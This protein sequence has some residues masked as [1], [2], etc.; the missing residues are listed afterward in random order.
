MHLFK[1][2]LLN[3]S[4]QFKILLSKS[5]LF[6]PASVLR[7]AHFTFVLNNVHFT[8]IP[9]CNIL[10]FLRSVKSTILEMARVSVDDQ[11]D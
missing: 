1:Q 8:K 7:G 6:L 10:S 4:F 11:I 2:S 9:L 5:C 3:I